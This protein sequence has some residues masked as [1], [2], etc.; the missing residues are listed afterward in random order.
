MLKVFTIYFAI[1]TSAFAAYSEQPAKESSTD[2]RSQIV[3]FSVEI[4]QDQKT[5]LLERT[6]SED[7][8]LRLKVKDSETIKKVAGREATRLDRDFASRFLRCQY[9]IPTKDGD[10]KVT[11]RLTMKGEDQQICDK[12]DKKSQEFLLFISQLADRFSN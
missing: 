11:L 3:L 7:Y 10:C 9:E 5:Y 1:L 2:L 12:D 6:A 8:F 4:L